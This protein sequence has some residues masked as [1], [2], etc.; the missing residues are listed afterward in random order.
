MAKRD[1][2]RAVLDGK[3]SPYVPWSCSFTLEATEKLRAHCGDVGPDD[4][5]DSHAL[6]FSYLEHRSSNP[7]RASEVT[8]TLRG[9]PAP[10]GGSRRRVSLAS[11]RASR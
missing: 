8:A 3:R 11:P 1:I 5:P 10:T 2:I 9:R 6:S 7:L 4:A